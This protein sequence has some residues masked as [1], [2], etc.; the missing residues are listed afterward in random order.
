MTADLGPLLLVHLLGA[1]GV[2]HVHRCVEVAVDQAWRRDGV[3]PPRSLDGAR[4][5]L[6]A[7]AGLP[8][9]EAAEN[10]RAEVPL[11]PDLAASG[12]TE[13]IGTTEVARMLGCTGR[14]VRD[15]CERGALATARRRGGRWAVDRLEV[16]ERAAV[17]RGRAA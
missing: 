6:A 8:A 13:W 4:A 14:N 7:A 17:A 10:R 9:G 1:D 12:S 2:R 11:R 3:R 15:L 16:A 5:L